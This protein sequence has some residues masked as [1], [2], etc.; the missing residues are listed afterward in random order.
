[1]SARYVLRKFAQAVFTIVAI[2]LLMF[3]LFRMMPGSPDRAI[4][5]PNLTP[6]QV[7]AARA[8]WGLDKPLVPDQ[9]AAYIQST[10]SGDL[11]YSIKYRGQPV[12]EVIADAA[13]PTILLI[14]LAEIIA[15]IAGLALGARSGWKRGGPTGQGG[16]G[17]RPHPLLDA[18]LR[19]RHA[20]D[21]RL[22]RRAGL[23]PHV[24]HDDAR[25]LAGWPGRGRWT[26]RGT[27]CCRWP[28]SRWA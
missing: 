1:M 27:W 13:G 14:G 23:V 15:I 4:K 22:R 3:L 18:V 16:R 26:W 20:P 17:P 2:V 12:T 9:L 10:M 19:D 24:G 11:G 6:Q 7:A 25:R 21:H 8:R 5:N 28:P